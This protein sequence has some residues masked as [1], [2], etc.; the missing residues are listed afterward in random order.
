MCLLRS[1]RLFA[2]EGIAPRVDQNDLCGEG[3]CRNKMQESIDRGFFY[4]FA[5]KVFEASLYLNLLLRVCQQCSLCTQWFQLYL[6]M[7]EFRTPGSGMESIMRHQVGTVVDDHGPC[8]AGNYMPCWTRAAH[9]YPVLGKW[10]EKLWKAR[11]LSHEECEAYLVLTRDGVQARKRN[12]D[13][14]RASEEAKK[15]SML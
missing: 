12:L 4:V 6:S 1:S 9:V 13:E 14:V 5:N 11:M 7:G 2:F 15:L 3:L 8:V 10:P